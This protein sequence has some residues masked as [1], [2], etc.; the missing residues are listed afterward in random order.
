[1][2]ECCVYMGVMSKIEEN[3]EPNIY[4]PSIDR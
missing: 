4:S 2:N 1:M 3:V